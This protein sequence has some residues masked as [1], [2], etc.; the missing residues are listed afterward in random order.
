MDRKRVFTA[1]QKC[2][3]NQRDKWRG[4][5][6]RRKEEDDLERL[7]NINEENKEW[8][9]KNRDNQKEEIWRWYREME[10]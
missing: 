4:F 8:D 2:T 10:R 3:Q 1:M 6:K 9:K 5:K 7:R